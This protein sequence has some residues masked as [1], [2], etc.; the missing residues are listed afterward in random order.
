MRRASEEQHKQLIHAVKVTYRNGL[1]DT[2]DPDW[3]KAIDGPSSLRKITNCA[4]HGSAARAAMA[5]NDNM[6]SG[7]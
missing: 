6:T 5:S 4:Y 3:C 2:D 1:L 7:K